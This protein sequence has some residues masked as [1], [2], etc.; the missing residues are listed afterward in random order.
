VVI[1]ELILMRHAEAAHA[2]RAVDDFERQLTPNGHAAA[3]RAARAMAIEPGAPQLILCSP[4]ARTQQ[5]AQRVQQA[6]QAPATIINTNNAIYL[7]TVKSLRRVLAASDD[8]ITRLLLI[9]HNPGVSLLLASLTPAREP[10]ALA[11]AEFVCLPLP[12]ESWS[13]LSKP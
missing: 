8:A 10:R 12:I 11:T 6:L 3:L 9:A 5:T 4:A 7:A 1:R 13:Q 2:V